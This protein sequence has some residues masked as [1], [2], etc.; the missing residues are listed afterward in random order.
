MAESQEILESIGVSDQASEDID[1]ILA[2]N[3]SLKSDMNNMKELLCTL[4]T[5][6]D[7]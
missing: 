5:G 1:V 6:K 2:E 7:C 3:A 4:H